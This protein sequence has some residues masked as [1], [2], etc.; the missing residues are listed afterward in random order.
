MLLSVREI[1]YAYPLSRVQALDSVSLEVSSGEYLAVVGANGSGKS[2]L[3]RCVTGLIAPDAGTVS[4][5]SGHRVPSALVF[6]SPGDQIVAETVELD[7]AFGPE[8]LGIPRSEMLASVPHA[9][10]SFG[11]ASFARDETHGL[12]SGRK[13][14]LALAGAT[15]LDPAILVLDEPASML[16]PHARDSLLV[17]LDRLHSSGGTIIHITH[18]LDE[19]SRADRVIVMD[20]GHAVFDGP[21]AEFLSLP[22]DALEQWG[23]RDVSGSASRSRAGRSETAIP[24]RT[25]SPQAAPAGPVLDCRNV[26]LHAI[27]DLSLSVAPGS[28]TAVMG[29]S[30]SGKTLL[31]ELLAGLRVPEEGTVVRGEGIET[32]L[33]VQESES[34]LFAE[35]VA[36]DVAYGPRNLGLAGQEL[37]ARVSSAMDQVGLPF[38]LFADRRT[39][40]LSGGE[41]RKAALAGILA[42]DADVILLDEPSSALD[43]RSRS[44]LL[45]LIRNLGDSGK[46]VVFTTNRAE[47]CA[48]ADSVVTLPSPLAQRGVPLAQSDA[49][50][51][52][53]ALGAKRRKDPRLTRE[54][55]TLERLRRGASSF[56]ERSEGVLQGFPPVLKYVC[57]LAAIV[58]ALAVSGLPWICAL[59]ALE[60]LPVFVA[61][62]PLKKL[63]FGILKILPWLLFFACIQYLFAP[64]I[65]YPALFILRFIAL[66]I[67]LVVFTFITAHTEIMYGME[68]IL[69]PLKAVGVPVRDV[70]LVTGI[71]FRFIPLLYDEAARITTARIIRGA[72]KGSRK[73]LVATVQS[74]A[75]LFVPLILRTLTRAE[76]LAQAITARYYGAG[77]NS[78]YL[79]WKTGIGH[80]ILGVAVTALAVLIILASRIIGK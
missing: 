26:S 23:L 8:N 36:D 5:E 21:P 70:S 35:F 69:F 2:T 17:Y 54:Q 63:F 41:R 25:A 56:G 45:G 20:S 66:Y 77:K 18:D 61:R 55:A 73:G 42:M 22:G 39:F 19:A 43:V 57:T 71:V 48:I 76:R 12:T 60:M 37:V 11:L 1:S 53:S 62:Y 33:A 3:A 4:I 32:A 46:T 6:Q 49:Q 38:G 13:Q 28:V 74:M 31:M 51:P 16:S 9:L 47:E 59:I 68:D 15:V 67:P 27:K 7:V 24:S 58:A 75:S 64:D 34:S 30:G 72:G 40:S 52:P 50:S 80:L 10:E 29:E 65:L 78:R 14:H 44:Q 79:H